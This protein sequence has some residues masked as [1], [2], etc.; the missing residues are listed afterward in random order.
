[1]ADEVDDAS[2]SSEERNRLEIEKR[3]SL[4]N[5]DIARRMNTITSNSSASK[6][7]ILLENMNFKIEELIPIS[8]V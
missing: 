8:S 2:L 1:M 5:Q 6:E 7:S 4:L 3:L